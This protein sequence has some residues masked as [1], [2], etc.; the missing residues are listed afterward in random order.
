MTSVQEINKDIVKKF[1]DLIIN[2]KDY[3]AARPYIGPRYKQHNPLV[4]DRPEGLKEF[5]EFLKKNYPEARSDIK[6][7]IAEED[8]VVLHV[9]STRSPTVHRAII[10]IF[11]LENGKIDEH[12]DV[13]QE[14]PVTSANENG[15]F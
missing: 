12:W 13:I 3:E 9:H 10:E 5:I 6:R 14:I 7:V 15:M 4:K 2:K 1:Y 8:Y 11:R